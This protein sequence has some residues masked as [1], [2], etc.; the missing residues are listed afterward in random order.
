MGASS[1]FSKYVLTYGLLARRG[2]GRSRRR[3]VDG[4]GEVGQGDVVSQACANCPNRGK[5]NRFANLVK[6][7][8]HSAPSVLVASHRQRSLRQSIYD[9]SG[10]KAAAKARR[11]QKK[12]VVNNWKLKD[13]ARVKRKMTPGK[14]PG[15]PPQ[16]ITTRLLNENLRA[17]R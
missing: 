17:G 2:F 13:L 14:P 4:V 5:Q 8:S 11:A 15:G 12:K 9:I 3:R 1:S 16:P 6:P 10:A 7:S